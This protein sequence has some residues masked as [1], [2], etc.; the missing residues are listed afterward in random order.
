MNF[1]QFGDLS[2]HEN[3][4]GR[5]SSQSQL[6]RFESFRYIVPNIFVEEEIRSRTQTENGILPVN[7]ES[8][9][10]HEAERSK[11]KSKS[12]KKSMF[13]VKNNKHI[14]NLR[15][16]VIQRNFTGGFGFKDSAHSDFESEKYSQ[17]MQKK[18]KNFREKR[19]SINGRLGGVY[20]ENIRQSLEDIE[21]GIGE[22]VKK[23]SVY[24]NKK[25]KNGNRF[26]PFENRHES[27][28]KNIEIHNIN[29]N[30]EYRKSIGKLSNR[31]SL[32]TQT[33]P[34]KNR[35]SFKK[36]KAN[37]KFSRKKIL[38]SEN[39]SYKHSKK[40]SNVFSEFINDDKFAFASSLKN[41]IVQNERRHSTTARD[42]RQ[43]LISLKN[44]GVF[45][46]KN[47]MK[48]Q[49]NNLT[50]SERREKK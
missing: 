38:D 4:A 40:N 21:K 35:K 22:V 47:K 49:K 8:F 36:K 32:G 17:K 33:K 12:H 14:N 43:G 48:K 45:K 11:K 19:Q 23:I 27:G 15:Q 41:S 16:K 5:P 6:P 34:K 46:K 30:N 31:T 29:S 3:S 26:N 7:F 10:R 39:S 1:H 13:N 24:S 18:A 2:R 37:S 28:S 20:A 42:I 25:E 44:S 50:Q 9:N